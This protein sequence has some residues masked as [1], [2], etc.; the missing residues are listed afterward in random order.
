MADRSGLVFRLVLSS[1]DRLSDIA[2]FLGSLNTKTPGSRS[3]A[4]LCF[5]TVRDHLR[6]VVFLALVIGVPTS[7]LGFS[8][9][10]HLSTFL[11]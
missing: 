5:V 8:D 2:I 9:I 11:R 6:T 4:L 7:S 1:A 10:L 3:R